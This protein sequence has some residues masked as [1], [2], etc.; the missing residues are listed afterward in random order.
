[1]KVGKGGKTKPS[2]FGFE[3]EPNTLDRIE[4]RRIGRQKEKGGLRR[5]A[6]VFGM[7]NFG[8]VEDDNVKRVGVVSGK[9]IEKGLKR[10]QIELE[11]GF[12]IGFA[13]GRGDNPKEIK[14]LKAMLAQ[15]DRFN[16]CEG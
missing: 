15:P 7:M 8:I 9:G 16:A 3:S 11:G 12:K 1:L 13:G 10:S 6:E 4:F 14:S 2:Q 5:K